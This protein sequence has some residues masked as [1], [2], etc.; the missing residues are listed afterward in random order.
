MIAVSSL[1]NTAR[2]RRR[3]F[4]IVGIKIM[5]PSRRPH[6]ARVSTHN[7]PFTTIFIFEFQYS[8]CLFPTLLFALSRFGFHP[9]FMLHR[10]AFFKSATIV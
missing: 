4:E 10:N 3:D 1:H 2:V 7:L 8:F 5:P 6:H 9:T